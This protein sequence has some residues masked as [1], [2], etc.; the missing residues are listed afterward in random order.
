MKTTASRVQR[1][2]NRESALSRTCADVRLADVGQRE[3]AESAE[4]QQGIMRTMEISV[5]RDSDDE[6]P[7][8]RTDE[9]VPKSLRIASS[10]A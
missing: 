4:S 9:I 7:L 3:Y 8:S 10:N 1:H 2:G 6:R 5:Q